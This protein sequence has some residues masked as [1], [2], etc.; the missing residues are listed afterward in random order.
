MSQASLFDQPIT[1]ARGYSHRRGPWTSHAAAESV[2][3]GRGAK[4]RKLLDA[5]RLHGPMSDHEASERTGF[6][7][8]SIQSLRHGLRDKV[9]DS[10][11]VRM[12]RYGR[13][14]I[15]WEAS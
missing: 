11:E 7:L 9:R 5:Y 12:S 4:L 13:P 6:P 1:D 15:L 14:N 8:S 10:G 2:R 3:V